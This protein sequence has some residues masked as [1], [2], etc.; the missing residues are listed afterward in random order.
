MTITKSQAVTNKYFED[1]NVI[2]CI[3]GVLYTSSLPFFYE[4]EYGQRRKYGVKIAN[5][6]LEAFH[7]NAYYDDRKDE[8]TTTSEYHRYATTVDV[9]MQ[10]IAKENWYNAKLKKR[11]KFT[12]NMYRML[13]HMFAPI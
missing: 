4:V 12:M 5:A 10:R 8:V 1:V 2:D 6:I 3:F 9:S 11:Y 13:H 7:E